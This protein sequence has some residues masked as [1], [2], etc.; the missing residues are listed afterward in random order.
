MVLVRSYVLLVPF[1]LALFMLGCLKVRRLIYH[2]IQGYF[3][4][5]AQL[6]SVVFL[7]ALL[8]RVSS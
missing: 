5:L 8:H 7:T 1:V 6:E 2:F 3:K 4:G